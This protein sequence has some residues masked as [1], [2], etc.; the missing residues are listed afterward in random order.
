MRSAPRAGPVLACVD[1]SSHTEGVCAAAGWLSVQMDRAVE[2]LNLADE[3]HRDVRGVDP[4]ARQALLML[5]A[6]GRV[7]EAGG[8]LAELLSSDGG[9]AEAAATQAR[10]AS[11][12]VV[13]RRGCSS[14]PQSRRL[15][16]NIRALLGRA[17]CPVCLAPAAPV[18]PKRALVML[19]ARHSVEA[20]TDFLACHP[21]LDG[22]ACDVTAFGVTSRHA[23]APV[24]A[25][26]DHPHQALERFL[27]T[28]DCDLV[29]LPRG[30]LLAEPLR[31]EL[32]GLL[33][34][35]DVTVLTPARGQLTVHLV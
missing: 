32:E 26:A 34:E 16:A 8:D 13:G 28:S 1:G 7:I 21:A 15:G 12:L 27:R 19:D 17:A 22:L 24:R 31:R 30:A 9:F 4:F 35:L 14:P 20:M 18:T 6:A 29:V 11:V 3:A 2:L 5:A 10:R 33:T 25:A 23:A